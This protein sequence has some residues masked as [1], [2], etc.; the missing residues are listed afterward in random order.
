MKKTILGLGVAALILGAAGAMVGTVLAY[1]GDPN[2]KGPNYS[3]ERH[4]TMTKTLQSGDYNTWKS[5]MAGR[6]RMIQVVN[7]SNFSQFA[8]MHELMLQGK[9]DEAQKIRQELGLGAGPGY[10][11]SGKGLGS[12]RGCNR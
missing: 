2:V 7:E 8:K 1:Q 5:L 9:T 11:K 6:G 10:G 12:G 3:V 4:E